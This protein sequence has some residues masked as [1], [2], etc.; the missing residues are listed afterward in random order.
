MA[1]QLLYEQSN[2]SQITSEPFVS[3]QVVYVIDQ[4]NSNYSGQIQ[5]DTSSLS[6]SGKYASYSEAYLQI[7]FV[8]QGTCAN[9]LAV[10]ANTASYL[11]YMC[12]LKN[13]YYQ[14]IH[15]LSVEYNNNN[16]I[17]LTP[18]T[19][20]YI[21]YKLMTSL[22][23]GDVEKFGQSIGFYPD[24][25]SSW[26]YYVVG[27]TD[28]NNQN[29]VF[30]DG[31][32][33]CNNRPF[34][35]ETTYPNY[36]GALNSNQAV[37]ALAQTGAIGTNYYAIY[38]NNSP[39]NILGT[40]NTIAN[41][42]FYKRMQFVSFNPTVAPYSSF[43]DGTYNYGTTLAK[44]YVSITQ[45][46][47]TYY[48][49]A[50]IR[51]KDVSDFFDKLPL[52]KGAYLRFI[53]NYNAGQTFTGYAPLPAYQG[54]AG[55][56]ISGQL[57]MAQ[58]LTSSPNLTNG[59]N[60][61][62]LSSVAVGQG[63][64]P[65]NDAV[66]GFL[67]AG[68]ATTMTWNCGVVRPISTSN[69]TH[70]ITSCRLYVPLYQMSPSAESAYLSL[71]RTK[72]IEY[73]DIYQYAVSVDAGG[74]FNTLLTNG[75]PNPKTVIVIPMLQSTANYTG[76]NQETIA[77]APY[78]SPFSSE[79]GTTSPLIALTNFNI[80]IA[81]VNQFLQNEQYDFEQFVNELSSQN[82]INGGLVDGLVSGLISEFD[83]GMNYRYYVCDVS[84]RLSAEDKVPKSV[85]IMGTNAS[86][87]AITLFV[88]IEF[89]KQIT[90]DLM[91]GEKIE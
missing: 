8:I 19:N 52:V 17:Q 64:Y 89:A 33:S 79:P 80:Q 81:G 4:N 28:L 60:P 58:Y 48:I 41:Y 87:V 65:N 7:P 6:N 40:V 90:I 39:N 50:R 10:D 13:G 29:A 23:R 31:V 42:G 86:S 35:T 54:V 83:Y 3:R 61:I 70:T 44:N 67:N 25:S 18:F 53:I 20:F 59:T 11:N 16:V 73:R 75:I 45:T 14:L 82:A 46:T 43:A 85:Q 37:G 77:I 74:S 5:L 72:T 62:M 27:T 22:S 21:N 63:G 76:Q 49:L 56:P 71:N 55:N 36:Y 47:I 30:S 38:N 26:S 57:G 1:D 88:F 15:S 66:S 51:L 9:N 78:Q 24:S 84:R 2:E 34:G 91:T 68:A 32:G 12:G 69:T